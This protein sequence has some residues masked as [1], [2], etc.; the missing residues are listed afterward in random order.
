MPP[1]RTHRGPKARRGRE[2][3]LVSLVS[4]WRRTPGAGTE[5]IHT[6]ALDLALC[7]SALCVPFPCMSD[8]QNQFLFD[9]CNSQMVSSQTTK[10]PYSL[11]L[12]MHFCRNLTKRERLRNATPNQE[13]DFPASLTMCPASSAL[14]CRAPSAGCRQ[15]GWVGEGPSGSIRASATEAPAGQCL[16]VAWK[17]FSFHLPRRP[18]TM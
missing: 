6:P 9:F 1:R 17:D 13:H 8:R 11:A 12:Q 16:C 3:W 10:E 7:S 4:R 18:P 2:G 15:C 14:R 5:S